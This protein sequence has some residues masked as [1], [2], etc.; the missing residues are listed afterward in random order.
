MFSVKKKVNT[1]KIKK[2]KR[3]RKKK[4][5]CQLVC[6]QQVD[7]V[8]LL[9]TFKLL[10]LYIF[11]EKYIILDYGLYCEKRSKFHYYFT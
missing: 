6:C 9:T 2:K 5:L 1:K 7:K 11:N 8:I 4:P 10:I 3:K